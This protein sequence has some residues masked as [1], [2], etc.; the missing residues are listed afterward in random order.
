[1]LTLLPLIWT[2]T[3]LERLQESLKNIVRIGNYS[4]FFM[5]FDIEVYTRMYDLHIYSAE[6]FI[7]FYQCRSSSITMNISVTSTIC[8]N[9]TGKQKPADGPEST[10]CSQ[11]RPAA[12]SLD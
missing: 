1:L 2:M 5:F 8:S 10:D 12:G 6:D 4:N 3:E 7:Y 11:S 9:R